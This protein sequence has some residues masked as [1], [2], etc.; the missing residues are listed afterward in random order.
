MSTWHGKTL[1]S[2]PSYFSAT[3]QNEFMNVIFLIIRE[4]LLLSNGTF[5]LCLILY[6][7]F[8]ISDYPIFSW[9]RAVSHL[10]KMVSRFKKNCITFQNRHHISE[11]QIS[12]IQENTSITFQKTSISLKKNMIAIQKTS[13]SLKKKQ[14]SHFKMIGGEH[15]THFVPEKCRNRKLKNMRVLKNVSRYI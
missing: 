13:I 1:L 15:F 10:R 14:V 4:T 3:T 9:K 7:F 11:K 6:Q 2:I 12:H 8:W 5:I